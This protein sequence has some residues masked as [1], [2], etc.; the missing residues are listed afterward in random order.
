MENYSGFVYLWINKINGKKYLGSHKGKIDD[1]Y[2]GSGII[3]RN[4]IKKYGIDNFE[5]NIIEIIQNSKEIQLREQYWLDYY[6]VAENEEFYNISGSAGG[7]RTLEGKSEEELIKWRKKCRISQLQ[8]KYTPSDN[9]L[10]KMSLSSSNFWKDNQERIKQSNR[11]KGNQLRKGLLHSEESK[12]KMKLS[13]NLRYSIEEN[14]KKVGSPNNNFRGIKTTLYGKTFDSKKDAAKQLGISLTSLNKIL[15]G[16][17]LPGRGKNKKIPIIIDNIKYE[18]HKDACL[19]LKICNQTLNKILKK[20][21]L[22]GKGKNK[23]SQSHFCKKVKIDN[24]EYNSMRD[25]V[26]NTGYSWYKVRKIYK[27]NHDLSK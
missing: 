9:A 12:N 22:I 18:S 3:F 26:K 7:G 24:V 27:E 2:I 20:E 16:N 19:K 8:R 15:L 21:T 10:M 5:R 13:Q 6:N 11:M 1:N 17:I 23:K 14:R 25:A 4:A